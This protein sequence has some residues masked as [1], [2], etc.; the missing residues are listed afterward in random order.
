MRTPKCQPVSKLLFS[1]FIGVMAILLFPQACLAEPI[2]S[3]PAGQKT[4]VKF[5]ENLARYVTWPDSSFSG[6]D[7]P[8][9]YCLLGESVIAESL[10]AKLGGK[11]VKK[12]GFEI[13]QLAFGEVEQSKDCHLVYIAPP[14][15]PKLRETI[16]ALSGLAILTAGDFKQF[17]AH[18]GMVG[19]VGSGKKGSLQINKKRLEASGLKASSKLYRVSTL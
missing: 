10:S 4:V 17:A 9:K 7:S 13:R 14:D 18:G 5:M 11:K 2:S 6:P 1:W 15:V 3:T 12:R 8:Y 16:A 19:F